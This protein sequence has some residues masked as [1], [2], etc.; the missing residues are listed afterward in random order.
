MAF[1][2][3]RRSFFRYI[4]TAIVSVACVGMLTA[5]GNDPFNPSMDGVGKLSVNGVEATLKTI[6]DGTS[7]TVASTNTVTLVFD[8]KN[9]VSY[10][11]DV[12]TKENYWI[13]VTTKDGKSTKD[14]VATSVSGG[15]SDLAKDKT[16][17]VTVTI[18]NISMTEGSYVTVKYRP[19]TDNTSRTMS[20]E[21]TAGAAAQ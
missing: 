15:V 7:K 8:I 21:F 16:Q 12:T 6:N 5:C 10:P 1:K 20:W 17:T 18:S 14:Y 4:A 9:C 13:T 11:L 19:R 3:N 2:F